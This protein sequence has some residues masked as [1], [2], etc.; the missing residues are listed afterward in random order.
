MGDHDKFICLNCG[1]ITYG[2]GGGTKEY[3]PLCIYPYI[4]QLQAKLDQQK[5][6]GNPHDVDPD[7]CPTW[8]DGCHC[9]VEALVHNI[10]RA[11]KAEAK[12]DAQQWR[13][14]SKGE[15]PRK[16]VQVLTAKYAKQF[17]KDEYC[18]AWICEDKKWYCDTNDTG[19]Y[20]PDRWMPIPELPADKEAT[21][22]AEPS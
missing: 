2:N 11:E 13:Y 5:G 18:I 16:R 3:C 14:L 1:H 10:E 8:Y 7:N 17:D 21:D 9:T 12:L 20:A 19:L 6:L 22:A 15:L 4:K